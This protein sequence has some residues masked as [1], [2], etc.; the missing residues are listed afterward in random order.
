MASYVYTAGFYTDHKTYLDAGANTLTFNP[1]AYLYQ[2]S[3][4]ADPSSGTS[5]WT[6]TVNG[7]VTQDS[8]TDVAFAFV[9]VH[10]T[11]ANKITIGTEGS[12]YGGASAIDAESVT[13][14]I[15]SGD[16]ISYGD[17]A[18]TGYAVLYENRSVTAL[19]VKSKLSVANNAGATIIGSQYGITNGTSAALTV[20]NSGTIQGLGDGAVY[21]AGSLALTNAIGASINGDVTAY[22]FG[23][24]IT[25]QG[26]INGT[27]KHYIDS[28]YVNNYIVD[29]DQDG[30]SSNNS[31]LKTKDVAI[32]ALAANTYTN[33]GKIIGSLVSTVS[34]GDD[35]PDHLYKLAFSLGWGSDTITNTGTITGDIKAYKD[36]NPAVSNL[37]GVDTITNAKGAFFYGHIDL[38]D[39]NDVVTNNGQM[40]G[41]FNTQDPNGPYASTTD[42]LFHN[43]VS[44]GNGNNTLA[45]TGRI[46]GDI[47][48]DAGM[49]KITNGKGA[50]IIGSVS[51]G[52][53]GST[54]Q[55]DG[56]IS[57]DVLSFTGDGGTDSDPD[58]V[59]NSASGHILGSVGLGGGNNAVNNAGEIAV[60]I[61]TGAGNDTITNTGT[62]NGYI[63]DDGGV[64]IITNSGVIAGSISIGGTAS[65]NQHDSKGKLILETISNTGTIKG[66]IDTGDGDRLI[67]NGG[68]IFGHVTTGA[69]DDTLNN[70][71]KGAIDAGVDLG[72]G[73]NVLNN[74]GAIRGA[75]VPSIDWVTVT[76]QGTLAT[77]NNYSTGVIYGGIALRLAT[78][79]VLNN[80]G[81]IHGTYYGTNGTDTITNSG[82]IDTIITYYGADAVTNTATGHILGDV[83]LSGA[84]VAAA[85]GVI[86]SVDPTQDT[87]GLG[88]KL[89]PQFDNVLINQGLI[90]GAVYGG[91]IGDSSHLGIADK[92]VNSGTMGD[93]YLYDGNDKLDDT[94]GKAIG[95]IHMGAGDDTFI[96]GALGEI[97]YDED[98]KD[99]YSMGAGN[100]IIY[101]VSYDGQSNQYDGGAGFDTLD[102]S[103]YVSDN[104][105]G[106]LLNMSNVTKD[107]DKHD[108]LSTGPMTNPIPLTLTTS[109][110]AFN[111]EKVVGTIYDDTIV[112]TDS[113]DTIDGS[114]GADRITGGKGADQLYAGV[115]DGQPGDGVRDIFIYNGK[116]ESGVGKANRDVIYNFEEQSVVG[117]NHDLILF[118]FSVALP[119]RWLGENAAFQ[120]TADNHIEV[121]SYIS[122]HQTIIEMD[123]DRDGKADFSIALDGIH[124]LGAADLFI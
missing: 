43:G 32:S 116:D 108:N 26:T 79:S 73:V 3:Y 2:S 50:F 60:G 42:G 25:N 111:F 82:Q 71:A 13:N 67:T 94:L 23:S 30:F 45:N 34:Q 49:D 68:T 18:G 15:N 1:G 21:S 96:G 16:I 61:F 100:D 19:T 113:K 89:D 69:G 95:E 103:K 11:T 47:T 106:I 105:D 84:A 35:G 117:S 12:I 104:H 63:Y 62:V 38:G 70:T 27:I 56:T 110:G 57:G 39:G 58:S 75:I 14:I 44:L 118:N 85:T 28:T 17:G 59:T 52:M 66:N 5:S 119:L 83:V 22:W 123:T 99:N 76:S 92:V 9:N 33:S 55:N 53:G 65:H 51:V 48:A 72:A 36:N 122:G 77:F 20:T 93:V 112:G 8:D 6:V 90:D 10:A 98:G 74:Y 24:K 91:D 115:I 86:T 120:G 29:V 81:T 31:A 102:F 114:L 40:R 107:A 97:V 101:V 78:A 124:H 64:N 87:G 109:N 7:G 80:S 37:V 46:E 4:F 41:Y 88:N 121:R 54:I